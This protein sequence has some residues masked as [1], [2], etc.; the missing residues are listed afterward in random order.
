[1]KVGLIG[2]AGSG[3]TT[4]LDAV[5]GGNR[6]GDLMAIPV[7]DAR[8]ERICEVIAPK[9]RLPATVEIQDNAA[10]LR[11][12][13]SQSGFAE[14]ARRMD[15]LLH[16]VREFDSPTAPFHAEP[17]PSRDHSALVTELL[18]ADLGI[19]EN[20][21]ARLAKSPVARQSGSPEYMEKQVLEKIQPGLENGT[22]I[23]RMDLSDSELN[24]L[25]SYQM[26]TAKP[27][28]VAVNC[29]ESDIN[30][31][32]EIDA[33]AEDPTFRICAEVEKEI[34]ALP[35]EERQEF[36]QDLGIETPASENMVRTVYHALGLVTFFTAGENITQAWPLRNGSNALKA[37]DTIHSDIAKGFIRAE[38]THYADFDRLGDL[39]ACYTQNLM[40]LEGK[41]YVVQDGDII[42]IRTSR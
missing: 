4:L 13:G 20:R 41:E 8:F 32:S 16:V 6:K 15:A 3:K 10:T 19:A 25:S 21:I 18:L 31:P 28:L 7:P 5:S 40:K 17:N 39:K 30:S 14:A 23:R 34:A 38:I 24:L 2:Y 36:L 12:A 26:L 9:K 33:K 11:E 22:P 29:S 1:M 42:N 35:A 27:M 37:A